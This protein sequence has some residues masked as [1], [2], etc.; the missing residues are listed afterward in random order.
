M[1]GYL[2]LGYGVTVDELPLGGWSVQRRDVEVGASPYLCK[3]YEMGLKEVEY[4]YLN[5]YC[6]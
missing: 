3:A 2:D 4:A 6:Y 5:N 1:L